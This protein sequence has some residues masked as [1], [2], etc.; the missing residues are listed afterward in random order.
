MANKNNKQTKNNNSKYRN[1]KPK[2]TAMEKRAY[3]TGLGV[4]LTNCSPY[5]SKN[6]TSKAVDMMTDKEFQSYVN[7]FGHG[8]DNTSIKVGSRKKGRW[9]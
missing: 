9:F 8:R 6:Q 4:G 1:F 2:Y 3:F 7:G 5:S